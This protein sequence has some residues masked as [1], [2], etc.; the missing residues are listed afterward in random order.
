M[1][2]DKFGDPLYHGASFVFSRGKKFHP[3]GPLSDDICFNE[4]VKHIGST[5]DIPLDQFWILRPQFPG[6]IAAL[7]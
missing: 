1:I 7:K 4:F 3:K 5:S 6:W 2:Q